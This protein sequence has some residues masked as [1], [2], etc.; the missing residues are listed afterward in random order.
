MRIYSIIVRTPYALSKWDIENL[1]GLGDISSNP[2]RGTRQGD[3]YSPFTWLAVFDVL[4]TVLD[5]QP[6]LD[7]QVML[8]RP[9]AS[10]YPAR[11]MCYADDL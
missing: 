4:L 1:D 8:R 3:V 2:E 11:P 9:N 10:F 6:A 7:N 5:N